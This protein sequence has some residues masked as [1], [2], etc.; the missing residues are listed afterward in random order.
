MK[1]K[2]VVRQTRGSHHVPSWRFEFVAVAIAF[3][4]GD[5]LLAGISIWCG[6]VLHS[7]STL[8]LRRA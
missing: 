1:A 7:A 6:A 4:S 2:V 3:V 5:A 8:P